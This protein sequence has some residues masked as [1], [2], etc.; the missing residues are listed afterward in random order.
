MG[1]Y[2]RNQNLD[3]A[4]QSYVIDRYLEETGRSARPRM[5]RAVQPSY[6]EEPAPGFVKRNVKRAAKV[7]GAGALAAGA[8]YGAH[9]LGQKYSNRYANSKFSGQV[10]GGLMNMGRHAGRAVN[11]GG[12]YGSQALDMGKKYGSQALQKGKKYGVKAINA[13]RSPFRKKPQ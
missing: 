2:I 10:D 6:E 9:R 1:Y 7:V 12:Q 13:V 8:A 3:E 5:R 4:V 11:M